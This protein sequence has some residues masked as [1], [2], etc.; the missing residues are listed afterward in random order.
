M[1]DGYNR[2]AVNEVSRPCRGGFG[3]ESGYWDGRQKKQEA[4]ERMEQRDAL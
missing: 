1:N 4:G 2:P 3:K